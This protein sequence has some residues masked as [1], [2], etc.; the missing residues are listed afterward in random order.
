MVEILII[1]IEHG[2][3]L[4]VRRFST[5]L[6]IERYRHDLITKG[7]FASVSKVQV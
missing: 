4:K 5:C 1:Y 6:E 3:I 2:F 7:W